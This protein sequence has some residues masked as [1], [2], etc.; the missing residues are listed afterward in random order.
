MMKAFNTLLRP[1]ATSASLISIDM[2]NNIISK[3]MAL[4]M[5]EIFNVAYVGL[6]DCSLSF[7]T[8]AMAKY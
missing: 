4:N 5:A 2:R 3:Q 7:P 1:F 8:E 6:A